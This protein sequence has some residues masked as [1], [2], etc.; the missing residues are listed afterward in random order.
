MRSIESDVDRLGQFATFAVFIETRDGISGDA[1][2][3]K[4]VLESVLLAA[5]GVFYLFHDAFPFALN[6]KAEQ[7]A[8]WLAFEVLCRCLESKRGFLLRLRIG[9]DG[10]ILNRIGCAKS[11]AVPN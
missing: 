4:H 9:R 2:V 6:R 1:G 5:S 11:N 10:Q 7:T 3:C 8:Q